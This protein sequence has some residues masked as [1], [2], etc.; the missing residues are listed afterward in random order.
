MY[1]FESIYFDW[2]PVEGRVLD[3]FPPAGAKERETALFFVH[4]GGWTAGS[5][6]DYHK[7]M[8]AFSREGYRCAGTDYRLN[9]PAVRQL[10]DI[11]Q[12]YSTFAAELAKSGAPARIAVFGGSAGAHLA[13]L[14]ALARPSALGEAI[15]AEPGPAPVAAIA[16]SAPVYFTPWP[17]IFPPI[18]K[19]M[20]RAAGV[21]P[22][23]NPELYRLLAPISHLRADSCPV[24]FL[25]G[26]NEHMFPLR[27]LEEFQ[28]QMHTLNRPC[29]H[30]TY[31]DAE[32][33]FF[34]DRTRTCQRLAFHDTLAFLE[35]LA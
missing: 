9:V 22:E 14:L 20:R 1:R 27:H 34:Y 2:P 18:E 23:E 17:E 3:L 19:S 32:H 31:P 13:L 8:L 12:G 29:R 24:L 10:G 26:A 35:S 21:P 33:G 6:A 7:L 11:R 4:G 16:V 28:T 15:P 5:R 25:S 30:H